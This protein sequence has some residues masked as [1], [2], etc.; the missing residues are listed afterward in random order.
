VT[1][2]ELDRALGRHPARRGTVVH[3]RPT[4]ADAARLVDAATE[5]LN[6]AEKALYAILD[7]RRTEGGIHPA[8]CGTP[9]GYKRHIRTRDMPPCPACIAAH[10]WERRTHPG[11]RR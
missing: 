1:P 2:D 4:L 3:L 5:A 9:S 10:R 7:Q 8:E 6:A 11:D